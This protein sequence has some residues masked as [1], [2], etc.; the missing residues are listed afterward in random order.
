MGASDEA[1]RL[2]DS[3]RT[4]IEAR[5]EQWTYASTAHTGLGVAYAGLDQPEKAIEFGLKGLE[6]TESEYARW[7]AEDGLATIYLLL[8][9]HE[10]ALDLL[11]EQLQK[12]GYTTAHSLRQSPVYKPLHG[13]P[14]YEALI[15]R[16]S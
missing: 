2:F 13:L 4:Y 14:R 1:R 11:E 6:G 16:S 3:A 9:D 5:E 7:G 8:G 15:A 12:P 10:K